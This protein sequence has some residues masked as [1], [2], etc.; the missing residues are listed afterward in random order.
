MEDENYKALLEENKK[1]LER[2]DAME[3]RVQ[4]VVAFNKTLLSSSEPQHQEDKAKRV[5][6]LNARLKE[7]LHVS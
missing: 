1:L 4:D 2:I 5:E 3:K 6:A 7:V